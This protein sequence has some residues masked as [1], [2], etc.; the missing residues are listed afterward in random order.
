MVGAPV[1][2]SRVWLRLSDIP[3]GAAAPGFIPANGVARDEA[4]D[5]PSG[6]GSGRSLG[7][8]PAIPTP[9]ASPPPLRD[10]PFET[11]PAPGQLA[12]PEPGSL[13]RR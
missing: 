3:P 10:Q 8:E 6:G 7:S 12:P 13:N 4:R 9:A 11:K 1:A 2:D 5:T